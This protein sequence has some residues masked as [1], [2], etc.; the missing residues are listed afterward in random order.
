MLQSQLHEAKLLW[1]N[2]PYVRLLE[3]HYHTHLRHNRSNF[4]LREIVDFS[5]LLLD[6]RK[7]WR[8]ARLPN[9]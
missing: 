1:P 4:A 9:V 5:K 2:S 7:F 6:P 3:R 8:T